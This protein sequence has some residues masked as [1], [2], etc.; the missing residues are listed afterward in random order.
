VEQYLKTKIDGKKITEFLCFYV[1]VEHPEPIIMNCFRDGTPWKADV[2]KNLGN[3]HLKTVVCLLPVHPKYTKI[4][5]LM[6]DKQT[7]EI[8]EELDKIEW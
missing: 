3:A 6:R 7:V 4:K 2:E 5:T 8:L 1:V